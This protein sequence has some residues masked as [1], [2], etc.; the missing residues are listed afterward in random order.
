MANPDLKTSALTIRV[1]AGQCF[2][3]GPLNF[4]SAPAA[5]EQVAEAIGNSFGSSHSRSAIR[6]EGDAS[7]HSVGEQAHLLIDLE[8]V[9]E[10]NSAGLALMLEWTGIAK[11]AGHTIEIRNIPSSLQQLAEVCQVDTLI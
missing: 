8:G 11:R 6:S 9:T 10:A 4:Q 7:G 5:L 2:V 1:D 3:S